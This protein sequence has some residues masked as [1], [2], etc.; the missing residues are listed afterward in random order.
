[1]FN[2]R[3]DR[4]KL[5]LGENS[6]IT[7][8]IE[9]P[10]TV[11]VDG[12]IIGNVDGAKVILGEH[13]YISGNIKAGSIIIGGKIDGHLTGTDKVEIKATGH[14]TGDITTKTLSIAEGGIFNG[15][16]CMEVDAEKTIEETDGKIVEFL[17][18]EQ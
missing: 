10:G 7:G 11:F 14:V 9:S 18:K 5:V 16:S 2:R 12:T 17:A 6:K 4:L 3:S 8:N 1:M 15:T 13:S